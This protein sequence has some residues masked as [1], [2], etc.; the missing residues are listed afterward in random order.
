MLGTGIRGDKHNADPNLL[1]EN[2][3]IPYKKDGILIK[4]VGDSA[5]RYHTRL[6][7]LYIPNTIEYLGYDCFGYIPSLESTIF[8]E[9][10]NTALIFGQ[11][12][13]AGFNIKI[14]RLP[15]IIL[16]V[17]PHVFG[18]SN[19]EKIIYCGMDFV[20][21]SWFS[22]IRPPLIYV[23]SL[24]PYDSFGRD[25]NLTFTNECGV[26]MKRVYYSM[27]HMSCLFIRIPFSMQL[28]IFLS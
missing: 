2:L 22:D 26:Y 18:W 14:V 28:I 27:P 8:E 1:C 13:F 11:G 23:H 25:S 7:T 9:R 4:Q 12:I 3:I 10:S 21:A 20:N 17:D 24:Y 19:I 16:S 6:K 15:S 5:F